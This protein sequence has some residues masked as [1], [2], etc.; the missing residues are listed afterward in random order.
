MTVTES[1]CTD[2][3]STM[4]VGTAAQELQLKRGEFAIAAHVGLVRVLER[5]SG[6]ARARVRREEV[7]RLRAQDGFP[8]ALRERLR[9]VGTAE[10][11]RLLGISPDRFTKLA[12][13]GCFPPI[14]F[15]LN[16][17]RSV[18]WLYLAEE[19]AGFA[20]REPHLLVGKSPAWVRSR[21][22]GGADHRAR[23]WRSLRIERLLSRTEDPW[24]RAAVLAGALDPVQLAEVVDDPYERAYLARVGSEPVYGPTASP[25]ARETMA[26]LMQADEPDEM[27][28]RRVGLIMELDNAREARPA[29]RPGDDWRPRPG[30]GCDPGPEVESEDGPE[31]ERGTGVERGVEPGLRVREEFVTEGERAAAAEPATAFDPGPVPEPAPT[32]VPVRDCAQVRD[33]APDPVPAPGPPPTA[34]PKAALGLLA[35]LGLR[36]RP[37]RRPC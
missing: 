26:R 8:E 30:P 17:Y 10:G 22:D 15:Y 28:W 29:P 14:T 4:A 1:L 27:L 6:G 36:R 37:Y 32:F 23:E 24:A 33:P 19:L 12:R 25:A 3:G 16:R 7:D 11:A 34:V 21:L 13:A 2:T 18:V 31:T 20:A 35:R 5:Q 9:T